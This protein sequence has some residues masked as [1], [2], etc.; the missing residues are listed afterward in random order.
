MESPSASPVEAVAYPKISLVGNPSDGYGGATL[1]LT[2]RNFAARVT[3]SPAD[4]MQFVDEAERRARRSE[5]EEARHRALYGS[6]DASRLLAASWDCFRRHCEAIGITLTART[7]ELAAETTIPRQIGMGGSSAIVRAALDALAAFHTVTLA[8]R[9]QVAIAMEVETRALGIEAGLMDRVVQV[10]DGL[11]FLDCDVRGWSVT[12]LDPASLPNLFIA[13]RADYAK[14]SSGNTL[15]PIADRFRAGDPLVR[16]V[17]TELA[18]LATEAREALLSGKRETFLTCM[19]HS[20]DQRLRLMPG[21]DARYRTLIEIGRAAGSHVAFPGSGGAVAGS[22]EDAAH[23]RRIEKAYGE[24]GAEA[25]VISPT[26]A[27]EIGSP[28]PA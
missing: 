28:L 4:T 26:E 6:D 23:L 9:D 12:R 18:T 8:R 22:F 11:I 24:I 27:R 25:V 7:C 5:G 19:D 10:H 13:W 14:I 1:G 15:S 21:M 2:I 17:M 16:S 3:A 20:M